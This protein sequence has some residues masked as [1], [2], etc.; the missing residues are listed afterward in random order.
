[1]QNAN[2][3]KP[4]KIAT[5]LHKILPPFPSFCLFVFFLFVFKA[6]YYLSGWFPTVTDSEQCCVEKQICHKFRRSKKAHPCISG[7]VSLGKNRV[8]VNHSSFN[9]TVLL[10]VKNTTATQP[11]LNSHF[12]R[13]AGS[14][15]L[16]LCH[17]PHSLYHLSLLSCPLKQIQFFLKNYELLE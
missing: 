12:P 5:D 7:Y 10:N 13:N 16:E 15:T 1:M 2:T 6:A 8:W 11:Y 9:P 3:V 4:N 14:W 17:F